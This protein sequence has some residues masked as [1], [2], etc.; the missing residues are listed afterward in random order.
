M[1]VEL[2]SE[3][4]LHDQISE[5]LILTFYEREKIMSTQDQL[6]SNPESYSTA[7]V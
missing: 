7:V 3:G 2:T 5:I 1:K 6:F 4:K